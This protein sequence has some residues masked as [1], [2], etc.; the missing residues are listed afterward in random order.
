[1]SPWQKDDLATFCLVLVGGKCGDKSRY[2][3]QGNTLVSQL[4]SFI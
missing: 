3:N 2:L 1:M 4:E